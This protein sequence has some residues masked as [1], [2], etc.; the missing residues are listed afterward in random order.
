[1]IGT[2][3]VTPEEM[4]AAAN[5]LVTY[6]NEMSACFDT[7]KNTMSASANYWTG[8]AANAHRLLYTEQIPKTEEF[9]ARCNEHIR[10]L[11]TMAGV[12]SQAETDAT[13]TAEELPVSTL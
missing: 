6:V 7:M 3:K 9:I 2:L 4:Q 5:E 1:M 13:R 10:D 11:N 12:Y 8:E